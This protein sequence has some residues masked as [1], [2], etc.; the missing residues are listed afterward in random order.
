MDAQSESELGTDDLGAIPDASK[1]D[2]HRTTLKQAAVVASYYSAT[3]T[4]Q[5]F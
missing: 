2:I 3:L 5:T 4:W 1:R